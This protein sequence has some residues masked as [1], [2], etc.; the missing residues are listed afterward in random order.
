MPLLIDELPLVAVLGAL[1]EGET[2][3]EGAGELRHKESDRLASTL[4][5]LRAM[6]VECEAE[7][8]GLVVRGRG[9]AGW[10]AFAFDAC[11][12]HRLAMAAAVAAMGA[13]GPCEVTGATCIAI[14]YPGFSDALTSLGATLSG[15][16]A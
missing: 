13:T 9:R 5:L 3:I 7:S 2:R 11:G 8:D 12:D 10:P 4:A 1:C 16:N 14:S 15:S 6:Q